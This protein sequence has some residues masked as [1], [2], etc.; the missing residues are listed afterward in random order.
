VDVLERPDVEH[1]VE[2]L[3]R[4]PESAAHLMRGARERARRIRA[5]AL[6]DAHPLPGLAQA[7]R[8]H[9]AAEAG[10]DDDGVVPALAGRRHAYGRTATMN[11]ALCTSTASVGSLSGSTGGLIS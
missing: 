7:I 4:I 3:A 1:P 6:E 9:G 8:H 10:A 5:S 2:P 11:L